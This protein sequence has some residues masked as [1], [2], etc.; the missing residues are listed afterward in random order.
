VSG[1]DAL[2]VAEVGPNAS[3]ALATLDANCFEVPWNEAAMRALLDDGLT[4]GWA[5]RTSVGE[6]L[7]AALVRLVADEGEILRLAVAPAHRRRGLATRLLR[8]V[9]TAIAAACPDGLH[10]EVRAANVAARHLYASAGFRDVGQ[11]R[12]YYQSPRDDA[13]LM[14]WQPARCSG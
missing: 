6:V 13:I 4:R 1:S 10:L 9:R 12:D 7:A 11:R 2:A 14:H 8:D 3:A 5:I